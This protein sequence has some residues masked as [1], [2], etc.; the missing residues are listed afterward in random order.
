MSNVTSVKAHTQKPSRLVLILLLII[1]LFFTLSGGTGVLVGLAVAGVAALCLFLQKTTYHVM[2]TTS[3]GESSALKT[4]QLDYI[5]KVVNALNE[6]IV[7]R[8]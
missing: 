5:T 6:A 3:G 2:L 4:H 1:G 8:G 7:H